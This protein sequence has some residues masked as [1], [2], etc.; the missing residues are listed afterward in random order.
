[1]A[2][3]ASHSSPIHL[4]SPVRVGVAGAATGAILFFL[5]WLSLFL[6]ISSPTHAFIPLFT[7]A[8]MRSGQA[9]GEGLAWSLIFGGV[10]G[11]LF[12]IAYNAAAPLA[13]R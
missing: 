9:L 7:P 4:L 3:V 2:T 5:C 12:A 10:L 11:A 6:P 8:E 13:R 1:M